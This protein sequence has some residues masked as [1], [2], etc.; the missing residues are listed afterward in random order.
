MTK[1]EALEK[2]GLVSSFSTLNIG[3]ASMAARVEIHL[4]EE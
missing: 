1:L 3:G 2:V 4:Q